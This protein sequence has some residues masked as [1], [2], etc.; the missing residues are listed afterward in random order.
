MARFAGDF[1]LERA[2]HAYLEEL[3]RTRVFALQQRFRKL[4]LRVRAWRAHGVYLD[5]PN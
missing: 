3:S 4:R 1:T 5:G 2:G